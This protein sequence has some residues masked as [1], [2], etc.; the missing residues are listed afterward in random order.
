MYSMIFR[1]L[2]VFEA[3]M[4]AESRITMTTNKVGYHTCIQQ[5]KYLGYEAYDEK[6]V[7]KYL[8]F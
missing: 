8:L 5:V 4:E 1:N 6:L 2:L 7:N 3:F